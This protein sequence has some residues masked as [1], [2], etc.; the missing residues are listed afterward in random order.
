MNL[1]LLA[2]SLQRPGEYLM[3]AQER[4]KAAIAAPRA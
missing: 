1:Y 4:A 2:M 3:A